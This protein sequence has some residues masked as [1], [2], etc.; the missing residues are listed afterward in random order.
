MTQWSG[1]GGMIG[2]IEI[3][4]RTN[5]HLDKCHWG[6]SRVGTLIW[7]ETP[8]E[9]LG[10]EK[11]TLLP[12]WRTDEMKWESIWQI[13][14]KDIKVL[15]YAQYSMKRPVKHAVFQKTQTHTNAQLFS[16]LLHCPL[17]SRMGVLIFSMPTVINTCG[18]EYLL[19]L[20]LTQ[21]SSSPVRHKAPMSYPSSTIL[22]QVIFLLDLLSHC[23]L[24]DRICFNSKHVAQPSASLCYSL[25]V[26]MLFSWQ[27]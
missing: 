10:T 18:M 25:V 26:I 9:S 5:T 17:N 16:L 23:N 7:P 27:L 13:Q 21:S 8:L 24:W 22:R 1:W 20:L 2:Y 19:V 12:E 6:L 11:S 4:T 15:L 14:Q 3:N